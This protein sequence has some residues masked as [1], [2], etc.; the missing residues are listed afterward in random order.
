MK[1]RIAV[2]TTLFVLA[3]SWQV[4]ASSIDWN[5][6]DA[7][8]QKALAS[9]EK[10]WDT[11]P[12]DRRERLAKGAERWS[13]MT[14]AQ[15]ERARGNL[16]RWRSLTSEQKEKFVRGLNAGMRSAMRRGVTC[17]GVASGSS[18]YRRIADRK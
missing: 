9:F 4:G 6:L 14:P 8:T 12:A 18:R 13:A 1:Q 5:E 16:Q 3:L 10:S 17:S 15:R 2:L 7:A 11:M